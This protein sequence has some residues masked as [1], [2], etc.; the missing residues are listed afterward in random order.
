MRIKSDRAMTKKIKQTNSKKSNIKVYTL[1]FICISLL[2]FLPFVRSGRTLVAYADGYN[3]YLPVYVYTGRYLRSLL[4][5]I[6]VYHKIP[7][8]DYSIGFGDDIIGTLNYYGFGDIFSLLSGLIPTRYAA[9][10]LSFEIILKYYFSGLSFLYFCKINKYDSRF[11]ICGS[12][13]YAFCGFNLESGSMFPMF[14][15]A[16]VFFPLF[17]LG[18][19]NQIYKRKSKNIVFVIAVFLTSLTGFYFLYMNTVFGFIYFCIFFHTEKCGNIRDFFK[20]ILNLLWRYLIGICMAGTIIVPGLYEYFHSQRQEI[21]I[22]ELADN[23]IKMPPFAEIARKLSLF[24]A[25]EGLGI[26]IITLVCIVL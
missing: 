11:S 8:F 10:G 21:S 2:S 23:L 5:N 7:L 18:L 4:K 6:I 1:I 14:S 22:G 13:A 15:S 19:Q 24:F 3:Q 12:I 16:A 25:P 17:M 9:Y 26:T 20:A